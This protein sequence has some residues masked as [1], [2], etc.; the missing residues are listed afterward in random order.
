MILTVMARPRLNSLGFCTFDGKIGCFQFVT[1]EPAKRSSANRPAGTVELKPIK[2]VNRDVIRAFMIV[3]VLPA[4]AA[5]LL[6]GDANKTIFI[7]QDKMFCEPAKQHG[8][9]IRLVCQP[10]NSHDVNVL[11]LG[12]I[13]SIQYKTISRIME[14]L[15][16]AVHAR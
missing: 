12:S 6:P 7:Q 10:A 5:N 11:D 9:D 2:S 3:K 16:A 8:F 15:V 1:Y 14:E 13:Q 4:I